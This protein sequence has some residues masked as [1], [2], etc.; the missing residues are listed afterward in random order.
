MDKTKIFQSLINLAAVENQF[1]E[2][3]IEFLTQQA[4][5][6]DIPMK[7][8]ETTLSDL[9]DGMIEVNLP[10]DKRDRVYLLKDMIQLLSDDGELDASEK[11][12]CARA[13]KQMDL[14]ITQFN[15][16]LNELAPQG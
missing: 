14:T 1:S 4:K 13:S 3:E 7:H 10:D 12:L 16:I 11:D 15:E 6:Y 2:Q 9:Q 8:F 5:L